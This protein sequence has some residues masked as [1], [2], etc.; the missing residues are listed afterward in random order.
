[1]NA[2]IEISFYP[3]CNEYIP[4]IVDFIGRLGQYADIK[5]ETNGLSTQI[6]GD[7]RT[8]MR[9]LTDEMEIS[10]KKNHTAVFVMKVVNVERQ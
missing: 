2:S 1:M 3:L 7:Y 9:I 10:F 4:E 8:M 6:F 5:T